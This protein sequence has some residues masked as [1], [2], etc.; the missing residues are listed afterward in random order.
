LWKAQVPSTLLAS[1]NKGV[2]DLASWM[3]EEGLNKEQGL[4]NL[5]DILMWVE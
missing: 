3:E 1:E 4:N 2:W 5:I